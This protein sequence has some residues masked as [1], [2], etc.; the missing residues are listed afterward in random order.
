MPAPLDL[1]DLR[2]GRLVAIR[3]VGYNGHQKRLW[4]CHCDCGNIT[5][6]TT[7][8][9]RSGNTR[10]CGCLAAELQPVR[11]LQH[12]MIDTPEYNSWRAMKHRT[13]NP[14]A[15]DYEY[16]GGRGIS[17]CDRWHSFDQFLADMGPAPTPEHTLERIDNDK[18]YGP[19][20]CRWATRTEQ[21]R[22]RRSN[23]L[24]TYQGK[25]HCLAVWAEKT[26]ITFSAL[27]WRLANGWS[28]EDALTR[29][30]EIH[31]T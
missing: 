14:S 26:G 21:A 6:V 2:F 18:P 16:Y 15:S 5:V 23:H 27:K 24:L 30:L 12:G 25:T 1:T 11:N 17:F 3:F 8:D 4:N 10:S 19:H 29:P 31:Q 13:Q 9:L 7:S 28:A 20:N 22:N